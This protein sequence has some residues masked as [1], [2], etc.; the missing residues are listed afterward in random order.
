[1]GVY[2]FAGVYGVG[3]TTVCTQI[4]KQLNIP[5]YNASDLITEKNNESYSKR[6]YVSDATKNQQI[7]IDAIKI[8]LNQNAKILLTGH[9]TIFDKDF[10]A[11]ELPAFVF[12]KIPFE[13]IILLS[14]DIKSIR[15]NLEVRGDQNFGIQNIASLLELEKNACITYCKNKTIPLYIH[16]M[17][18]LNDEVPIINFI[19]EDY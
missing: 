8:R 6:K 2:F 18:Y 5:L 14:A 7:L 17:D 16:E 3:K 15:N 19:K 1:M 11:K 12:D 9:F 13:K 10:K 4:S